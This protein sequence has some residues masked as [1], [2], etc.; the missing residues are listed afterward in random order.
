MHQGGKIGLLA[1][2]GVLNRS[3]RAEAAAPRG[4]D[5]E[6]VARS[7]L[8]PMGGAEALD[9]AVAPLDVVFARQARLAAGQAC[10]SG[11]GVALAVPEGR[12]LAGLRVGGL[13][14][15]VEPPPAGLAARISRSR[16]Q[17]GL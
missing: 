6:H 3:G 1:Y 5:L 9:S 7:D 12:R 15:E 11:V 10:P 13:E 4:G 8:D 17:P 2:P 14:V 16:R